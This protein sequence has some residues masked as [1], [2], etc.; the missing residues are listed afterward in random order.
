MVVT[1]RLRLIWNRFTMNKMGAMSSKIQM[2]TP[3][4]ALP[5]RS[6]S[7]KVSAKHHVNGNRTVP[8]FPAGLQMAM[9]GMG[10]FWGAERRFWKQ[11]GVYSTQVG[12]AGGFTP[13]P[14]YEETCTEAGLCRMQRSTPSLP[15]S[16]PSA[17]AET[18]HCYYRW[19]CRSLCLKPNVPNSY[20]PPH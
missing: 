19:S 16:C 1:T 10:C 8:P 4:T 18:A 2:P 5:G 14:T 20:L 7:L 11:A 13:N 15:G 12:Y 3:E 9:F 6:E 17:G